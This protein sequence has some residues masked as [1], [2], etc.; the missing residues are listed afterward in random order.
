MGRD[1][2][3]W[4]VMIGLLAFA[5][6]CGFCYGKARLA[7]KVRAERARLKTY[8][9][10]RIGRWITPP[11]PVPW[12]ESP[13]ALLSAYEDATMNYSQYQARVAYGTDDEH[14]HVAMIQQ[15]QRQMEQLRAQVLKAMGD[16]P[17]KI[18][19]FVNAARP[20]TETTTDRES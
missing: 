2:A 9:A 7:K 18:S 16:D 17:A 8:Q 14:Q 12:D 20:A 5:Y 6:Y 19:I 13:F 10:E 3:A 11:A 1:V 4:A 15:L